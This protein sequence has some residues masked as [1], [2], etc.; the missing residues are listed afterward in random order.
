MGLGQRP[1]V[2]KYNGSKNVKYGSNYN[3]LA[4]ILE[5]R[6]YKIKTGINNEM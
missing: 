3:L 4:D 6:S 1:L 5:S 2:I